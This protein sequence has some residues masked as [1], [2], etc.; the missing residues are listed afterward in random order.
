MNILEAVLLK[1]D[2]PKLNWNTFIEK[3]EATRKYN[4]L[5]FAL[6]DTS[7]RWWP[8]VVGHYWPT[9]EEGVPQEVTLVEP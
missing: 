5:A 8:G 4:C 3:G 9:L 7:Q 1:R 2:F 6:N